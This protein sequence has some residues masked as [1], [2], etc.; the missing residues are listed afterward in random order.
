VEKLTEYE[1]L[2]SVPDELKRTPRKH[3]T[4]NKPCQR[5]P[6]WISEKAL[7]AMLYKGPYRRRT[8][9]PAH[10][11]SKNITYV[12]S[13]SRENTRRKVEHRGKPVIIKQSRFPKNRNFNKKILLK[14]TCQL[15]FFSLEIDI[16][17]CRGSCQRQDQLYP[18]F[19][20]T[21]HEKSVRILLSILVLPH[22]FY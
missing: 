5:E 6:F 21:I 22:A 11:Q 16:G 4:C 19:S 10:D 3:A 18:S 17:V 1:R 2:T 9:V 14:N 20:G 13:V 12:K 8:E 7:M 15:I